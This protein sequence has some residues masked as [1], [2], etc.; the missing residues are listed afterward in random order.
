M[1]DLAM[2]A[3]NGP[4]MLRSIAKRQGISGRYLENIMT[5]LVAAG[6]IRGTRGQGGGFSLAKPA[7]Q[8]RLSQIVQT[9]EGALVLASCVDNAAGCARTRSCAIRGVWSGLKGAMFSYLDGITLEAV[10][11]KQK[12]LDSTT[13]KRLT[14]GT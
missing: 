11:T 7:S 13:G 10:A 6:L 4:I 8:I 14:G 3:G 5:S 9:A 12:A 2:H 1:L